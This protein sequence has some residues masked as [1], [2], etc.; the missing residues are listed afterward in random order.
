MVGGEEGEWQKRGGWLGGCVG[1]GGAVWAC[2]LFLELWVRGE[3][4]RGGGGG[5]EEGAGR[6]GAG[7]WGGLI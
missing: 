2:E 6:G 3:W 7:G 5:G 4:W 1:A